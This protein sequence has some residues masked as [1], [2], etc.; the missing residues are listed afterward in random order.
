M[1]KTR[2]S[3]L[4]GLPKPTDKVNR[5]NTS[6][7]AAHQKRDA[8]VSLQHA[9]TEK[10]EYVGITSTFTCPRCLPGN[11]TKQK[12]A[13]F[14][15]DHRFLFEQRL[16]QGNFTAEL[17]CVKGHRVQVTPSIQFEYCDS[18]QSLRDRGYMA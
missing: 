11:T 7:T 2:S 8:Q 1:F 4:A 6:V 14:T 16:T 12:S 9:K 15:R 18:E 17:K 13:V 3:K 5:Q 10:V